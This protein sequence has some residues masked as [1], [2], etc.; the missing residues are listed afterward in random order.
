MKHTLFTYFMLTSVG[1]FG[2]GC[3]SSIKVH[4]DGFSSYRGWYQTSVSTNEVGPLVGDLK[5]GWSWDRSK[6]IKCQFEKVNKEGNI[7]VE[8][9]ANGRTLQINA[10]HLSSGLEIS[11][12]GDALVGRLIP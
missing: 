8:V 11:A 9:R 6:F 3:G 7:S 4:G 1:L 2:V 10:D 12:S 5:I